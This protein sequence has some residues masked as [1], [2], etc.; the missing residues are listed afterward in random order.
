MSC[1]EWAAGV[2]AKWKVDIDFNYKIDLNE[3]FFQ[4]WSFSG[5]ATSLDNLQA[6]DLTRR[7]LRCKFGS[8]EGNVIYRTSP[9]CFGRWVFSEDLKFD[10]NFIG[11]YSTFDG[12]WHAP[13]N[14]IVC[15]IS[16]IKDDRIIFGHRG[17]LQPWD[18]TDPFYEGGLR[19]YASLG[20]RFE[21]QGALNPEPYEWYPPHSAYPE[22]VYPPPEAYLSF[23]SDPVPYTLGVSS[24][25][26]KAVVNPDWPP[27]KIGEGTFESSVEQ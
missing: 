8:P 3:Y 11:N 23:F 16:R 22:L 2:K 5:N 21:I 6:A 14:D 18:S 15:V 27:T 25:D 17:N 13:K 24:F 4:Q 20:W 12:S 19:W 10:Q 9:N 26:L 1:Y 7:Q